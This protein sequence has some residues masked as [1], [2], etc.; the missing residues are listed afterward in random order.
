MAPPCGKC[1]GPTPLQWACVNV[2]NVVCGPVI[3]VASTTVAHSTLAGSTTCNV[4][5]GV[6][7]PNQW[8]TCKWEGGPN[9]QLCNWGGV[10]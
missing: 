5:W 2:G 1:G 6:G 3:N 7:T 9:V 8:G 10:H 4:Q